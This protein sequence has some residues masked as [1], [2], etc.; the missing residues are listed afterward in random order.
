MEWAHRWLPL[1]PNVIS[2]PGEIAAQ[3]SGGTSHLRAVFISA[4]SPSSPVLSPPIIVINY[5]LLL[6]FDIAVMT[7]STE[8]QKNTECKMQR[9]KYCLVEIKPPALSHSKVF[10][11]CT[12]DKQVQLTEVKIN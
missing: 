10:Y 6:G 12:Q 1:W 11:S 9:L 5:Q 2:L 4:S 3:L 7:K 8:V